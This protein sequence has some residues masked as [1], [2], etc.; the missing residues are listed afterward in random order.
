VLVAGFI[1]AQASPARAQDTLSLNVPFAF[2]AAGALQPAG[3]YRLSVDSEPDVITLTSAAGE[4]ASIRVL[5]RMEGP[6][7]SPGPA[8][9]AF[10]KVG[11]TYYLSEMWIPY[12]EG[13]QTY[14]T[15]EK[16]SRR[17]VPAKVEPN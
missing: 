8:A 2:Q 6:L 11:E 4:Q 10:E 16:H 5:G 9:V 15:K 3:V 17:M 14:T 1:V 13:Y 7:S 12:I